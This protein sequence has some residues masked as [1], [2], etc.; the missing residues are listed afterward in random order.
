MIPV[1]AAVIGLSGCS[2]EEVLSNGTESGGENSKNN[3]KSVTLS[4]GSGS[5]STRAEGPAVGSSQKVVFNDGY[6]IFASAQN[7]ITKVMT[8]TKGT[9]DHTDT[10]VD[11]S[12]LTDGDGEEITDVPGHS[13][14]AW[15]VGN[16]P[17]G[18]AAP[19]E[20]GNLESLKESVI[21]YSSQGTLNNVTLFGGSTITF[22]T[23]N[24]AKF[25]LVPLVARIEIEKI[26]AD[27]NGD[28]ASFNV[29]GIFI[30]NYYSQVTLGGKAPLAPVK[31]E[32]VTDFVSGS[33]AYPAL[34][35]GLLFD[36]KT[37]QTLGTVSGRVC[38]PSSG[39]AWG[40][41][42]PAPKTVVSGTLSA[43]HI[44]IRLSGIQTKPGISATYSDEWYLTVS[45]LKVGA[46]TVT[47]LEPGKVYSIKN[48]LFKSSNIQ[49]EPEQ[50][51]IDVT[52]DV[53]LVEW[54]ILDTSVIFGQ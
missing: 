20:G 6:L 53:T 25:D 22:S 40:Y 12:L 24:T 31:N 45:G 50:E 3:L 37:G 33:S 1:L 35:A 54:D 26:E 47:S 41:S 5:P 42:L 13:T 7:S 9:S 48:I 29:D 16:L 10:A 46:S 28:I 14:S 44:V 43:P 8:V 2:T 15:I 19:V 18:M 27:I 49:P 30:N 11:I 21:S 38:T 17:S 36:Y 32:D 4:I 23:K 34:E 51:T 52:V 39:V